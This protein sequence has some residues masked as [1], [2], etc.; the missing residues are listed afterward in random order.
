LI[1]VFMANTDVDAE[2]LGDLIR[3]RR[4]NGELS[5]RE[6]A[7]E[8]GV[9]APTLQRVESGQIPNTS[10]LVRIAGWLGVSLGDLQKKGK[11]SEAKEG[12]IIQVHLRAVQHLDPGAAEAIA[13]AVQKLYEVFSSKKPGQK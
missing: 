1:D 4:K 3:R 2:L 12:T 6:A 9:S 5:L 10:S 7:D 8:I 13:E 11:G